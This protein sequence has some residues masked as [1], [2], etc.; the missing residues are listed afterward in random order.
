MMAVT[1][2]AAGALVGL[3]ACRSSGPTTPSIS[4]A[5]AYTALVNWQVGQI[6]PPTTDLPLPVVYVTAED[7]GTIDASTQAKVAA[8]TVDTAKVRF[9]D[10]RADAIDAATEGEPV[11]DDGV[12]LIVEKF[13]GKGTT[14]VPVGVT[15]YRDAN[16]EQHLVLTV[17]AT[18]DGAE[19][20]SSS[21]RPS[22]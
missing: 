9:A 22:G 16:D 12:L 10:E 11:K 5:D 20:S 13:D 8:N 7:G 17:V 6:G 1:A 2:F 21:V 3:A 19:I 15:V 14:S 18:D 4:S